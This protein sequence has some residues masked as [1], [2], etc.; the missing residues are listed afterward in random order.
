MSA[1]P[2][3]YRRFRSDPLGF[4]RRAVEKAV[5]GPLRFGKGSGYDAPRYWDERF[6]RYGLSLLGPGDEGLTEEENRQAYEAARRDLLALCAREGVTWRGSRVLEV[7]VGNGFWADVA[8]GEG[9]GSYTGVDV[10]DALFES[11]RQRFPGFRF[12]RQDVCEAP[13][14]GTYDLVLMI[15]V[16]Q[17]VVE[18]QKL[19]RAFAHVTSALAGGGRFLVSPL[20]P[21][22]RRRM[23]YLAE[24]SEE[25]V[26]S[27]LPGLELTGTAPFRGSLLGVFR[28]PSPAQGAGEAAVG[29]ASARLTP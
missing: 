5:V 12:V 28:K 22:T 10:T 7:G 11:H 26:R 6:R 21:R 8:R 3:A 14:D 24:W 18:P 27:L 13:L 4:L 23:F 25:T 19:G 16:I 15:D 1:R 2:S 29:E 20:D 17:H 9:A